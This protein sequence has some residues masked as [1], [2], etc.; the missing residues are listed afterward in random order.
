MEMRTHQCSFPSEIVKWDIRVLK[1]ARQGAHILFDRPP[2]RDGRPN[3]KTYGKYMVAYNKITKITIWPVGPRA[4]SE[5]PS[6]MISV[7][8]EK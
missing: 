7:V 2:E 5:A 1:S 4:S 3:K 8:K 6:Y